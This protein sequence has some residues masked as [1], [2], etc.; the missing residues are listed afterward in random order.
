V[1]QQRP[2]ISRS[3]STYPKSEKPVPLAGAGLSGGGIKNGPVFR[4][5]Q[6]MLNAAIRVAPSGPELKGESPDTGKALTVQ[7]DGTIG[8][9]PWLGAGFQNLSSCI[10]ADAATS[11]ATSDQTG[12]VEA[13]FALLASA[14]AVPGVVQILA[15]SGDYGS[16]GDL[17][18]TRNVSIGALTQ[19]P[20]RTEPGL[21]ITND[22]TVNP[23]V[24]LRA[25][26]L[27]HFGALTVNGYALIENSTLSNVQGSGIL[28][29][30][31]CNI[32]GGSIA[33]LDARQSNIPAAITLGH[34]AS[35]FYDCT[36]DDGCVITFSSPGFAWMTPQSQRLFFAAGGKLVNGSLITIGAPIRASV[37]VNVPAVLAG[38]LNYIS[39][40][41]VG[42]PLEGYVTAANQ[43]IVVTPE[44]DTG[45][46][47]GVGVGGLLNAYADA[48]D[49]IRCAFIGGLA[50]GAAN[51]TVTVL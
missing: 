16:S 29:A 12:N 14:L 10:I 44:S 28:Q 5:G 47:A 23:N 40:T 20:D 42:T 49:S 38:S 33:T 13:P 7:P 50:G 48:A 8:L 18:F 34:G 24:V 51:F 11:L 41:L 21:F 43:P 26:K 45:G 25:S 30:T 32:Y 6:V 27:L 19:D 36:F 1:G 31:N 22:W 2:L 4:N 3:K 15:V 9:G 17:T 46:A 35:Y 39:T 37:S